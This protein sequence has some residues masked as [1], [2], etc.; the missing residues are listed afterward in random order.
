MAR[1]PG[2]AY[3]R[4]AQLAP[5]RGVA[6]VRCRKA[7]SWL[8]TS[9]VVQR[10]VSRWGHPMAT[11]IPY[12][13]I[14]IIVTSMYRPL[15]AGGKRPLLA[16]GKRPVHASRYAP[17]IVSDLDRAALP[18]SGSIP[19]RFARGAGVHHGPGSMIVCGDG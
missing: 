14:G 19:D 2:G 4:A 16:G 7:G 15:L 8:K 6:A 13:P 11:T 18:R 9:T 12:A 5:R 10:P 17:C 1:Y 3:Q